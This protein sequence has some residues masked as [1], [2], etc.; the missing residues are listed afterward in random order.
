V[1]W[2]VCGKK[3]PRVTYGGTWEEWNE[4]VE[5]AVLEFYNSRD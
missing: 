4:E 1:I 2:A 3:K 5:A